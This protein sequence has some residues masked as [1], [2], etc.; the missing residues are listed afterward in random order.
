[1]H[2]YMGKI[3][4]VDLTGRKIEEQSLGEE[5]ARKYI[6]G[7][8][9]A[10]RFI[11]DEV[12]PEVEPFSPDN[13]LVVATG[14][15]QA[16]GI[17][18][19]G[20]CSVNTRSPLTGIWA[21]ANTGGWIGPFLKRTGY[22]AI[23]IKGKSEKPAYLLVTDSGVE[24][25]DASGL[26]GKDAYET[27]G[28]IRSELEGN[29]VRV[30]CIGQGGENLVRY[31]S[32]INDT[33]RAAGRSGTGAVMG[34]KNLKAFAVKGKQS[35]SVADKERLSQLV[36]GLKLGKDG[37]VSIMFR[38]Y[39]TPL[40]TDAFEPIGDI[41][42][43]YWTR[44]DAKRG[45]ETARI[46]AKV[47]GGSYYRQIL[48]KNYHCYACPLGCGRMV[49][50]TSP[51]KYAVEGH[52]PE[53]ETTI[54]FGPLCMV[55]DLAAIAKINDM[56]NRYGID[57][58]ETGSIIAFAMSCYEK[59]W[60]TKSDT[61]GIELDWG[62]ADASI[63]MVDRIGKREGFG[64][65][66]AEGLLPAAKEIG[67][68]SINIV[69]HSK[70]QAFPMHD[71]R[72]FPGLAISYGTSERGA[73]HLH[74]MGWAEACGLGF[75]PFHIGESAVKKYSLKGQAINTKVSQDIADISDSLIQC[76]FTL[77]ALITFATQA[78]LLSALTGWDIDSEELL[79]TGE[80][81]FNLKRLFNC[82]FGVTRKDDIIPELVPVPATS[83]YVPRGEELEKAID[84]YYE[85]RGW[86]K[87]G[88]P[89][90]EKIRELG[91]ANVSPLPL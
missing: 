25:K 74:G 36:R 41:P 28:I 22:D 35:V 81:M 73:C 53:Q 12:S 61:D 33:G 38:K 85:V 72:A 50:V 49:K 75:T 87:D 76:Q 54:A 37:P 32:I 7:T 57:T 5:L 63:A 43:K 6:G 88:I 10:A 82:R 83:G 78:E 71:P 26:W 29:D 8:G 91:I 52:G 42:F 45:S 20:R 39:G 3:L 1:M 80:R 21:E 47:G 59:G 13:L 11:Y 62:N 24:I 14:P 34:S 84:E 4:R 51:E 65:V 89:T 31:A 56:C 60:I 17:P 44:A 2:G 69:M 68:D 58:I 40:M 79:T 86:T 67:H 66:L 15:F 27:E 46:G 55:D 9:L 77:M 16:T 18:F 64:N 70:G 90:A 30:A 19:S 23:I 48:T